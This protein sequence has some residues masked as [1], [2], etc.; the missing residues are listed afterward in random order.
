[1]VTSSIVYL[2]RLKGE[3]KKVILV[4]CKIMA[5]IEG[6]SRE[7]DKWKGVKV[8]KWRVLF[9]VDYSGLGQVSQ[10]QMMCQNASLKMHS[11]QLTI[12][13]FMTSLLL[14]CICFKI[15]RFS[16]ITAHINIWCL[17]ECAYECFPSWNCWII[18]YIIWIWWCINSNQVLAIFHDKE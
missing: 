8:D 5:Y 10:P 11:I 15:N 9:L 7:V 13:I 4:E 14:V 18:L 1:M 6:R 3:Q 12:I 16:C 2:V 17:F